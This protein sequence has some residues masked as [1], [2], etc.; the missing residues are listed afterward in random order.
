MRSKTAVPDVDAYL[1]PLRPDFAEA[2]Q[3]VRR[4]IRATALDAVEMISYGV[5]NYKWH[6]PLVSFGA[7]AKHCAFY[8]MSPKVLE[9][10]KEDLKG[11]STSP[12]T[13]RF[14]PDKLIP[15]AVLTAIVEARV[16]ENLEIEAARAAKKKK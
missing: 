13:I 6:G 7:A 9:R 10:F 16:A 8:G 3:R 12:G 14:T 5:P 2:L 4:L 1:A 15:E 11:F